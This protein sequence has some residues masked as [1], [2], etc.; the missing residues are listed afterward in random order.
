MADYSNTM[1]ATVTSLQKRQR[2]PKIAY[3]RALLSNLYPFYHYEQSN[4]TV[5]RGAQSSFKPD[6]AEQSTVGITL[7]LNIVSSLIKYK[8]GLNSYI[9]NGSFDFDMSVSATEDF[10]YEYSQQYT[11]NGTFNFDMVVVSTYFIDMPTEEDSY[12]GNGTFELSITI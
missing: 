3:Q 2:P 1:L 7:D 6:T 4:V 12:S 10:S 9:G 8:E 11:G 5:E